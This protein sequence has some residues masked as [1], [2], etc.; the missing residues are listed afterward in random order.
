MPPKRQLTHLQESRE[1]TKKRKIEV[2]SDILTI[3][4]RSVL[5][6]DESKEG[7]WISEKDTPRNRDLDWEEDSDSEDDLE[8][9]DD[10][11]DVLDIDAF[12]KLIRVAQDSSNFESHRAPYSRGPHLSI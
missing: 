3:K 1:L 6:K 5:L 12:A 11:K 2:K 9:I 4:D 7:S 8:M 10:N